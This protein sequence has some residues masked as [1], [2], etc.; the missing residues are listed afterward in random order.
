MAS[1][2]EILRAVASWS[3]CGVV[4]VAPGASILIV[5][6]PVCV[7]AGGTAVLNCAS[8]TVA[9]IIAAAVAIK[10]DFKRF[11]PELL[12]GCKKPAE[13]RSEVMRAIKREC[14]RGCLPDDAPSLDQPDKTAVVAVVAI[15]A[16]DEVLAGRN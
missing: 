6:G 15:I 11:P 14:N 9:I 7:A 12:N 3:G 10:N 16:H 13:S 4:V 8:A 2:R 5:P 1:S